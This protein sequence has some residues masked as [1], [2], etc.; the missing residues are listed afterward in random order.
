MTDVNNGNTGEEGSGNPLSLSNI[1]FNE[2]PSPINETMVNEES[3][4][5][6]ESSIA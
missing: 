4:I 3:K 5:T 6:D 1:S 2:A